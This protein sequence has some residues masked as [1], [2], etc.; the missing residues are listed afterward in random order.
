MEDFFGK[1]V[2]LASRISDQARGG[3]ILV[4]SLLKELTDSVGDIHFG[5]VQR[6]ELKGLA[7]LNR[8]YSVEWQ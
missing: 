3:G 7:G 2:I 8:L 1:N 4:S 6:V 5:E